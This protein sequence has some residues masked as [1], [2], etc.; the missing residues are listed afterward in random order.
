MWFGAV[1]WMAGHYAAIRYGLREKLPQLALG[2][3]GLITILVFYWRIPVVTVACIALGLSVLIASV[4]SARW[5]RALMAFTAVLIV[6]FGGG[7][8]SLYLRAAFE[9]LFSYRL[10]SSDL[11]RTIVDICFWVWA[12]LITTLACARMH[13]RLL[14][15]D[16][17]GEEI[18]SQAR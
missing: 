11:D 10:S 1:L 6:G 18:E 5:S 3:C 2:F 15:R 8:L 17:R 13:D 4:R 14:R 16:Q 12:T 9:S 7:L